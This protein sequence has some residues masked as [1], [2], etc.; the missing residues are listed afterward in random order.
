MRALLAASDVLLLPSEREGIALTLFEALAMGV[1]PV[2]ADVGGQRELITPEC[3][4][5]VPPGP[6]ER[7]AYVAALR[8]LLT[9]GEERS[10]MA[11]AGRERV[12]GRF[13]HDQM[14]ER[15]RALLASAGERPQPA[16][17][18]GAGLAA[19]TL[20]IEHFQLEER[21]RALAPVRL[22]LRLRATPLG[23]LA[24]SAGA[25]RPLI[26]R[27]D[28]AAYALRRTITRQV[29]MARGERRKAE[30]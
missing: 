14:I 13:R 20:A 3:G 27:L 2:A 1:T 11:Q 18:A 12:E 29:R 7:E 8:R 28:R 15:M 19:A 16:V 6:G 9:Y 30:R 21:L 26:E 22:A 5:L 24:G 17:S 10:R 23:R 4:V 25:L